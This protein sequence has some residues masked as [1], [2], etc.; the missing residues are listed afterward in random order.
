LVSP[1]NNRERHIPL[2][3]DLYEILFRRR[4][5]SGYVFTNSERNHE[6]FTSHRLNEILE[7]T[8]QKAQLRKITWH[9]LRHTFATQ[10]TLR[11]V[12]LTIVK[13]LLGHSSITTTM[14][15]SHVTPSALRSAIGMLNPKNGGITD[16]GQPAVN[17]VTFPLAPASRRARGRAAWAREQLGPPLRVA[18]WFSAPRAGAARRTSA[19]RSRQSTIPRSF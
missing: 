1:K 7:P 16:F 17:G 10:L 14:R 19:R 15:Y 13:E 11:G 6:P 4:Q 5:N 3:S 18:V 2:D 9:V 8:C 12:P